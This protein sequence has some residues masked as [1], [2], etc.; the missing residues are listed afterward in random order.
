MLLERF[1]TKNLR[2]MAI[3][4]TPLVIVGGADEAYAMPLAVTIRSAINHLSPD[5]EM[6]IYVLD[7]GMSELSKQRLRQSWRETRVEV[8]FVAVDRGAFVDLPTSLHVSDST[9]LRLKMAELLPTTIGR[10]IYLDSDMLVRRDLTEL[11]MQDFGGAAVMAVRDYAAP[12]IDPDCHPEVGDAA[13]ILMSSRQPVPNFKELNIPGDAEYFNAGMMVVDVD[14]WRSESMAAKFLAC[15]EQNREHLRWW[16]QYALNVVLAGRWRPLDYRWNQGVHLFKYPSAAKS[17][18][19]KE[20]YRR[21]LQDPWIV[22]FCSPSK[23]WDYFSSHPAT[24]E[25]FGVLQQTAWAGWRPQRPKR[26]LRALWG[27]HYKPVRDRWKPQTTQ[28]K[29]LFTTYRDPATAN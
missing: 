7:G 5:R 22:H 18:F 6:H 11:W 10:A 12:F 15:L 4:H 25:F 27:H 8:T 20:T 19:E 29:R 14:R 3:S 9:Y 1:P 2:N 17:P 16:D 13:K 23:P 24:S 26:Y 28:L 21:L